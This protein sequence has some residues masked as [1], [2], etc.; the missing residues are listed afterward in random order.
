MSQSHT[1]PDD[2]I[3]IST[4][5]PQPKKIASQIKK[6]IDLELN[7]QQI[8]V[9]N[10]FE[11]LVPFNIWFHHPAYRIIDYFENNQHI[12]TRSYD[13]KLLTPVVRFDNL[14]MSPLNKFHSELSLY[15]PFYPET[16]YSMY[17]FLFKGSY[18]MS[19][20]LS[21]S[22]E[23]KL[24]SLE[25]MMFFAE[26]NGTD[27]RLAEPIYTAW[28]AGGES[29]DIFTG[30]YE[31]LTPKINY[32]NQA[33]KV[34][35]IKSTSELYKQKFDFIHIDSYHVFD[36]IVNWAEEE[37]DLHSM[38][39]YFIKSM[40]YL[41]SSGSIGI[42]L[43]LIGKES[44]IHLLNIAN[45]FFSSHTFF[46]SSITH[47]FN[48][49]VYLY[50]SGFIPNKKFNFA[51]LFFTTLYRLK[52]HKLFYLNKSKTQ[53]K[54]ITKYLKIQD[55]WLDIISD[56]IE[57][58]KNEGTP[59]FKTVCSEW[60]QKVKL[61]RI[62]QLGPD[63]NLEMVLLE[64]PNTSTSL[65]IKMVPHHT[66]YTNKNYQKLI[67]Y[68]SKLNCHK[69]VMDTKPSRI[70]M[71]NK[72]QLSKDNK[73][74]T[75]E[76]LRNRLCPYGKIKV[77]LDR[78]YQLEIVTNAWIKLY[79]ILIHVPDILPSAQKSV[80]TFHIC[81]APGAFISAMNY[82][83]QKHTKIKNW[84]WYA[85]TL[86]LKSEPGDRSKENA[87]DLYNLIKLYPEKWLFGNKTDNSGDITHSAVIKFYESYVLLEDIS[88]MTADAGIHQNPNEINNQEANQAKITMGQVICIMACLMKGGNAI[89]KIFLPLSE[90]LSISMIYLLT[91]VFESVSMIKPPASHDCNSEIYIVLKN[92]KKI[93]KSVLNVLYDL[94]DDPKVDS[95][96]LLFEKID[97]VFWKSL[98]HNVVCLVDKQMQALSK[99]YYFYHH[100]DKIFETNQVINDYID[101]WFESNDI[102]PQTNKLLQD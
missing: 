78:K 26:K 11:R 82:Y 59:D 19:N 2:N 54:M 84:V 20:V 90:P 21:I 41:K 36:S 35:F 6:I 22:K 80:K 13:K 4:S 70:F 94:L 66:L 65:K 30:E 16:F 96:T 37:L 74:L 73:L 63:A 39:F 29:H 102:T 97:P 64:L 75:W 51:E 23:N 10:P 42:K 87:M 56:T 62:G 7:I 44:W 34:N 57:R 88:F 101:K 69:R 25:A 38:L 14:I 8:M 18:Q 50:L 58:I 72:Y 95:K 79:E 67:E 33:Y 45:R 17:E 12:R 98:T 31:C 28:L 91:H 93:K 43:K 76:E 61:D 5:L 81:D 52:I 71:E 53:N 1:Q 9:Q 92:Y 49:E 89:L 27:F 48:S 85:Q 99:N 100:Y 40:S 46:R 77:M 60:L 47:P 55:E 86:Y 24:G 15:Q 32:L 3:L 83:V 68:K